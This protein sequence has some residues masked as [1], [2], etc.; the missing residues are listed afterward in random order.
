MA[1][2]AKLKSR[3]RSVNSTKQITG[4]ME[5]VSASKMRR[6]TRRSLDTKPFHQY[7]SEL[8]A[9]LAA[10]GAHDQY[11][12]FE[13]RQLKTRLLVVISSDTG[14]AGSYNSTVFKKLIFEIERDKDRN[15]ET[16]VLALGR[17]ASV[18]VS[19]L[20]G[21]DVIGTY[22][23]TSGEIDATLR[24][25]V[26]STIFNKYRS[27]E[28]QAADIIYTQFISTIH[29]EVHRWHLLPAGHVPGVEVSDTVRQAVYEPSRGVVMDAAVERLLEIQF[30]QAMLDSAASEHSQ[31]MMA[32]KN[33]TDNAEDIVSDLT[34]VMNKARQ[35]AITNELIDINAGAAAVS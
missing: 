29:Q 30:I 28:I 4:A 2:T 11:G 7:A 35:G 23:G 17:K 25:A 32:M 6:A 20:E 1:S 19:R 27:G 3:I 8:L 16:E 10:E 13:H 26:C 18:F 33:A 15:V 9:H 22:E 12:F 24:K 34:I 31:R 5:L 14:L 21:V